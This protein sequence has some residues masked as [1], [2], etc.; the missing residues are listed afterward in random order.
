[1]RQISFD[2]LR[3]ATTARHHNSES[4]GWTLNDWMTA[5]V[6]EVGEAANIMKKVRRGDI[7]L[8]EARPYLSEELG[9]I[10]TYLDILAYKLDIDLGEA[11]RDKFN[12]VSQRVGS[13]VKL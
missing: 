3:N 5:L 7:S 6:G 2:D 1:M 12:K 4:D 11:T 8:D 10:Q 13:D 9:D